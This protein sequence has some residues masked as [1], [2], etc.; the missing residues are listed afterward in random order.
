[1]TKIDVTGRV[2]LRMDAKNI[3]DAEIRFKQILMSCKLK[4]GEELRNSVPHTFEVVE[5]R[6]RRMEVP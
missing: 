2:E 3:G 1:M 5:E 4:P 6:K